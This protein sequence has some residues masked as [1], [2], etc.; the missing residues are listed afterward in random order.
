MPVIPR[1]LPL[2]S[3]PEP[4]RN[5][6]AMPPRAPDASAAKAAGAS[7]SRS[8]SAAPDG[9]GRRAAPPAPAALETANLNS[10]EIAS[11]FLAATLFVYICCGTATG[12]AGT[13]GWVLHVALTFGL[14]ITVLA[15]TIG[16]HSGGQINCAVTLGLVLAGLK[17]PRQAALNAAAQ[18][19][20]SVFG[21]V[22]LSFTVRESADLTGN[23]ASNSVSDDYD[24]GSAFLGETIMTFTLMYVILECACNDVS[25][26]NVTLA[27]LAIGFAVFIAHAFLIPI[28]GCSINP[29]RSFGP[30]VV[31]WFQGRGGKQFEDYHVFTLAPCLGAALA[32]AWYTAAKRIPTG[33]VP[34]PPKAEPAESREWHNP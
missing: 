31:S 10:A 9:G 20:G 4:S 19:C 22:L 15:Y 16:H 26:G 7:S 33:V 32:A 11:E 8:L 34:R 13:P 18:L 28:D 5:N 12:V 23:L 14:T 2:V 24:V 1:K 30:A 3:A 21:A 29:T 6:N 25:F 27:P 17:E